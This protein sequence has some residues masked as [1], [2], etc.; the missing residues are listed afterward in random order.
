MQRR[1]FLGGLGTSLGFG[2]AA[3]ATTYV[4]NHIFD[5]TIAA[6]LRTSFPEASYE[7]I[8]KHNDIAIAREAAAAGVFCTM[9]AI[10]TFLRY[11]NPS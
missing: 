9:G 6:D 2:L 5:K 3:G 11:R 10:A 4:G 1:N 8:D 7:A